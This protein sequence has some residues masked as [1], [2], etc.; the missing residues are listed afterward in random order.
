[1]GVFLGGNVIGYHRALFNKG[2]REEAENDN[3]GICSR[4]T[5]IIT[6]YRRG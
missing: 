3:S 2:V 1:M 6:L 5:N 4:E